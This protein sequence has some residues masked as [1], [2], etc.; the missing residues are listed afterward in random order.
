MTLDEWID[1][2]TKRA[3]HA[4]DNVTFSTHT[5]KDRQAGR[6]AA[7]EGGFQVGVIETLKDLKAVIRAKR[8]EGWYRLKQLMKSGNLL[9]LPLSEGWGFVV[10]PTQHLHA[11]AP[12]MLKA[13]KAIDDFWTSSHPEGPDGDPTIMGGLA[14]IS[15]DTLDVWRTIRAAITKAEGTRS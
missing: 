14:K 5:E 13:L 3:E 2:T 12:D 9:E 11:A 7:Y 4:L 8:S 10:T 6:I 15:D 1:T